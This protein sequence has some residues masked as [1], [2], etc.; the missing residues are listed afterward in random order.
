MRCPG[1]AVALSTMTG[2]RLAELLDRLET[3]VGSGMPAGTGPV[4]TRSRHR[5]A[6]GDCAAALRRSLSAELPELA[7]EDLRLAIGPSAG[8]PGGPMSRIFSTSSSAISASANEALFHV[9]HQIRR[10]V[11]GDEGGARQV[12]RRY[13]DSSMH[14]RAN[15]RRAGSL[16]AMS[17]SGRLYRRSGW[18]RDRRRRRSFLERHGGRP[19]PRQVEALTAEVAGVVGPQIVGLLAR[20]IR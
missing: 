14:L 16:I 4:L 17:L 19:S 15:L 13:P 8:L 18:R 5:A 10:L 7:A 12:S 9:K 20:A 6:L 3:L 2:E 1:C 11:A